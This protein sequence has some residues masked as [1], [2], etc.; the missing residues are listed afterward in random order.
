MNWKPAMFHHRARHIDFRARG[1]ARSGLLLVA[2]CGLGACFADERPIA[3]ERPRD[4]LGPVTLK[5]RVVYADNARDRVVTVDLDDIARTRVRV[6]AIGRRAVF[7]MPTPDQQRV[8]VLTRGEEAVLEGQIDEAP[9]LWLVDPIRSD[10]RPVAYAV[11]SPFDRLAVAEDGTVA[12]AYFSS[13]GA[14][15]DG[16]FRNPSELAIIHLD[17]P[18]GPDNPVLRTVRSFGAAPD[19]I[20]LSPPMVIPGAAD[21]TPRILAFVLAQNN[22]TVLD[23]THP[24]RR[25][26]SIRLDLG[27]EPVRPRELVF[28]PGTA[29]A[30]LRSDNARDVLEILIQAEPGV[31]GDEDDNDYQPALAELGAGG[32]P[33][34]IAVYDDLAGRRMILAATPGTRELVIID[35]D[36][37]ELDTVP[38]PDPVD[39]ILLFPDAPDTVPRV[40]VLASLA[41][42]LPRVHLMHLDGITDDL[43]RADL[44]TVTLSEPVFD[45]VQV[46]GRELGMLVHDTG[47]TVLGLLDVAVGSVTPLEGVGRLDTYAFSPDGTYLIGATSGVSRIG[48]L[49]LDNLHPSDIRLDDAPARVLAMANGCIF[50]DHGDPFGR[51]TVIPAATAP[52]SQA[53]VLTGFLLADILDERY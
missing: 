43:V 27:G 11:G 40:A 13:G 39:R 5:N 6:H 52:R 33:A 10:T 24:E 17:Q 2:A 28:A 14:D 18:P 53:R 42:R 47:R 34:D 45:V 48:F 20:V 23:A 36:T 1:I 38:V 32:G 51:A 35:A 50:V 8:A 44:A 9:Q 12:V 4:V 3:F 49:D 29:T 21:D 19:G 37:G 16:Y 7:L 41:S 46:P 26:V 30:Y 15:A 25:E 22:V 31:V